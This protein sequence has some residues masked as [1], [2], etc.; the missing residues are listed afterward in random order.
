VEGGTSALAQSAAILNR[1]SEA[2]ASLTEHTSQHQLEL[3]RTR[4]ELEASNQEVLRGLEAELRQAHEQAQK[5]LSRLEEDL[6]KRAEALDDRENTHV[7]REL[8]RGMANLSDTTLSKNLLNRSLSSFL[9][10]VAFA[11]SAVFALASLIAGEIGNINSL[12]ESLR[13][14]ATTNQLSENARVILI[15]NINETILFSQIRIALQSIGAAALI[16]FALRIV[17]SRY[18]QVSRWEQDLH[19]F[20]LDTE[21]AGF[22]IEGDWRQGRSTNKVYLR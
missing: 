8:Q 11:I 20:R 3:D 1:V 18:R 9:I 7:R 15:Q 19:R 2:V 10:P 16:W 13:A 14:T 21:R 22:L 5:E 17:S 4:S 6:A 12:N